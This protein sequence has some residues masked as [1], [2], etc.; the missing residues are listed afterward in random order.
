[1]K[2][3]LFLRLLL[4]AGVTLLISSLCLG[5]KAHIES[6]P[7]RNF[8]NL[9]PDGYETG[10]LVIKIKPEYMQ[11]INEFTMD[12]QDESDTDMI[13][14]ARICAKYKAHNL[15]PY[16]DDL[17]KSNYSAEKK[18][19]QHMKWGLH[20][21]YVMEIDTGLEKIHKIID[22]FQATGIIE[23]AEPILK[24][25]SHGSDFQPI[26]LTESL[27]ETLSRINPS[28]PAFV[29]QWHYHNTGQHGGTEGADIDLAQAWEVEYGNDEV[30]VAI[31]DG[32]IDFN[33][34][35]LAGNMWENIGYNFVNQSSNISP[36]NHGT[37][38]A[39][40]IAAVTNNSIGVSGIAGGTGKSDGVRLMS[41]Q[42][43]SYDG[44]GGGSSCTCICS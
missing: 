40:T 29:D 17:Y 22:E 15:K 18:R 37:H 20:H 27:K 36:H 13:R 35:D 24:K 44:N 4:L 43:F 9:P 25:Y 41:C 31:I 28:D 3:D 30:I 5:Q 39:G 23:I 26:I 33:H 19:K 21:W 10:K 38:V 2:T 6:R 34:E 11:Q 32:G 14:F 12:K 8:Q 1:M 16:F 7:T 42:V